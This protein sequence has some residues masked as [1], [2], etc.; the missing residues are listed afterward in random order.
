MVDRK[1][2]ISTVAGTGK[3]AYSGDGGPARTA[4]LNAP[5][6][7]ALDAN[8]NVFIADQGNDAVRMVNG[9]A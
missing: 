2:V 1:R 5:A 3:A 7:L 6:G 8:G 9:R 4:A